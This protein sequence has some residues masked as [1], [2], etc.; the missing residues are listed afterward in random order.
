MVHHVKWKIH[1]YQLLVKAFHLKITR[2]M[3]FWCLLRL[4]HMRYSAMVSLLMKHLGGAL[5]DSYFL[6]LV[7]VWRYL[8]MTFV[9]KL[10]I[11]YV[12]LFLCLTYFHTLADIM[13]IS[14]NICRYCYILFVTSWRSIYT[15]LILLQISYFI[16][17]VFVY[18]LHKNSL[19]NNFI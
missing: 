3:H 17:S 11:M 8:R 7:D 9:M 15:S 12:F 13:C 2:K 10:F 6:N 14:V 16:Y 5:I 18:M 19:L 1:Y 4:L